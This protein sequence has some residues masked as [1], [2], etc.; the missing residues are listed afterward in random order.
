MESQRSERY[1]GARLLSRTPAAKPSLLG[2]RRQP[3]LL[4]VLNEFVD[5]S[6]SACRGKAT[7]QIAV[8]VLRRGVPPKGLGQCLERGI[9]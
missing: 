4:P 9:L 5:A 6:A 2:R 1:G 3:P 8:I 7:G